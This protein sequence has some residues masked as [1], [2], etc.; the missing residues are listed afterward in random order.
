[1]YFGGFNPALAQRTQENAVTTAG[2]AFGVA[3]GTERIGLYTVDDI[4]GF[5]PIEAGN[6]RIE[7]LYFD[8]QDRPAN[9]LIEGSTI[10][11]GITAQ[12]FP[13][14]APTGIV[15][16]RLKTT[17]GKPGASLDIERAAYGGF[18]ATLEANIPFD[19]D[20]LALAVS[21]GIRI[22]KQ[23]SGGQN[24]LRA[25]GAV[26]RWRPYAAAEVTG[27]F[28]GF[29]GTDEDAVPSF[30]PEFN[31]LPPQIV[32][33][34]FLGQTWD[35]KRAGTQLTGLTAKLP[36]GR[37]RIDAG[38]F[39][40]I[41]STG[42][43]YADL[44]RGVRPDG[45]VARRT[46]VADG[47]NKDV[48]IS[49]EVRLS[50]QLRTGRIA[51]NLIATARGRIKD[52][53]FGGQTAITLGASTLNGPDVRPRPV[54]TLGLN[55]DDHVEQLTLGLAYGMAWSGRA[56]LNVAVSRSDYR[57]AVDFANAASADQSVSSAPIL[58]NLNGSV[59]ITKRVTLFGGYVKGLEESLIAPDIATNRNEAPPAI[60]TQ[61]AE[62]GLRI[63]VAQKVTF[64]AGAFTVKK[65]YFGLDPALRFGQL[66]M[67]ENR[68][69]ELSLTGQVRPGF[70]VVAGSVFLDP[71]I[72][73][74]A[75]DAGRIGARPVGSV[76][77]R[78]I[79]NFDWKPPHQSRWSFDSAIESFSSRIGNTSNRLVAPAYATLALGT[80]YRTTLGGAAALIRL[81]VTNIFNTYGWLVSNSGGFTYAPSRTFT[82]QLAADL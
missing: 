17:T 76:R 43:T 34:R 78:S 62:A 45:S 65:P 15:D 19:G 28:G 82:L 64:V 46:I 3:V 24:N 54:F 12:G 81:Q 27:V 8:Q 63:A 16:Y 37:W 52:R 39:R 47:D 59:V 9:R 13:F 67:V 44:F 55:D 32:R 61:Q 29:Y 80:R 56:A 73:G 31:A 21:S 18:S 23:P 40:S 30:F 26:L 48:S 50:H 60:I 14:P 77:R 6:A 7:G 22:L 66:G 42:I 35:R 33:S 72:A 71:R 69:V 68:G 53:A 75:V 5:N 58:Y 36:F 51:H 57:K 41:K 74:D 25:Y 11:V 2:D 38:L 79:L 4:R 10:R 70:T 49:G 1:L 20:R